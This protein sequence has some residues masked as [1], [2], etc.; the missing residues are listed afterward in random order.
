MSTSQLY[1]LPAEIAKWQAI[2][3][4]DP[5]VSS[6][7]D[8][9]APISVAAGACLPKF[10]LDDYN[11]KWN[12]SCITDALARGIGVPMAKDRIQVCP[13][14]CPKLMGKLEAFPRRH[15]TRCCRFRSGG[16]SAAGRI[17]S[18]ATPLQFAAHQCR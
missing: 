9:F 16:G 1:L 14:D 6:V 12:R 2:I 17:F 7:K 11:K 15:C 3:D 4:A 13:S 10:D 5:F 8:K 18:N